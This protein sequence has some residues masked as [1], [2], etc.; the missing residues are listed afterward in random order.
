MYKKAIH[1]SLLFLFLLLLIPQKSTSQGFQRDRLFTGGGIGLQIGQLTLIDV[2]P[3]LGY[4]LT[5]QLA[6][7]IGGTYQYY[8]VRTT[9]YK[10][11]TSIWGAR[12]FGRY[13]II[14]EAFAHVE[15]E[16]LNYASALIDP[17]GYFTG[18]TERV[19][20]NN[21]LVG[22]GYR[23]SLGGNAW[24]NLIILWNVNESVYTL[25]DNPIIR[26]GVDLGL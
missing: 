12:T 1:Q 22:G 19:G 13:Y 5:D 26:M 8:N 4:F 2:S 16:Y 21:V 10:Y 7:G 17:Y 15:Y 3:H 9:Y 24:L 25:Y 6:L 14:P 11:S 20:V 18:D 23:Q